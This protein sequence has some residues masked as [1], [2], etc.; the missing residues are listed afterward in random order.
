MV[1]ADLSQ[2]VTTITTA[3][4]DEWITNDMTT[5]NALGVSI[6]DSQLTGYLAT[7]DSTIKSV[8]SFAT[9]ANSTINGVLAPLAVVYARVK[10]LTS[11]V[12]N[13]V[14][15]VTTLGGILPSN[16]ISQQAIS[17]MGQVNAMTQLPRLYNLQSV[18]GRMGG[19]LGSVGTSG[20]SLSTAGGNL[21][22]IA[23]KTY[24]DA[25]AW[26]GLAKANSLTDPTI[27]GVK[28]LT[29]P[30]L[31]DSSGGVLNA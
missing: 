9:A 3:G 22:Q 20:A 14:S 18:L 2:P 23:S 30:A 16:P 25:M 26:T 7:L 31:P 10:V 4:V 1:L 19:N 27:S 21:Y 17:L 5:A 24:G 8:S 29:I 6:G 12:G 15:N 13:V 28:T 11:S